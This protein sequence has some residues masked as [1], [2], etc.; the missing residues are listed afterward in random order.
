M[1]YGAELNLTI[2]FSGGLYISIG[3]DWNKYPIN[4]SPAYS[5]SQGGNTYLDGKSSGN[6]QTINLALSAGYA[7]S[8]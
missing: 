1:T 8:N 5:L 6:I 2:Y 3:T 4:F 7:F